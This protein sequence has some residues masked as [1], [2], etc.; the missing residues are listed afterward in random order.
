MMA[1]TI[2]KDGS[3]TW[4]KWKYAKPKDKGRYKGGTSTGGKPVVKRKKV[5]GGPSSVEHV[6]VIG[7]DGHVR[8]DTRPRQVRR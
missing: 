5:G 3:A 8:W 1:E 6:K 4:L 7:A 2:T